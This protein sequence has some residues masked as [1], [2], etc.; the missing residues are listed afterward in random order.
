MRNPTRR[1]LVATLGVASALSVAGCV[2]GDDSDDDEGPTHTCG[3]SYT[4]DDGMELTPTAP[5]I[6]ESYEY[7]TANGS[8][9]AQPENE[10]FVLIEL[11]V[12]N[13]SGTWGR[14][15][16]I[17]NF[18]L[19]VD[20]T[21]YDS[22]G[23]REYE[24]DDILDSLADLSAGESTDGILPFDVPAGDTYQLVYSSEHGEATWG[25]R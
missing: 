12:L 13:D 10:R 23:Q 18:S 17:V 16:N 24:R 15:P 1:R 21:E 14:I 7:E 25:E 6:L 4:N 22:M 3:E 5:D 20:E 19:L 9:T 11:T 2:G 8:E